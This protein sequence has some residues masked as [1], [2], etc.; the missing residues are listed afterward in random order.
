MAFERECTESD[1]EGH[2]QT[3]EFFGGV[4]QYIS[5]VLLSYHR[6]KQQ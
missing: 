3:F 6:S 5:K 4:P 2:A 1:W